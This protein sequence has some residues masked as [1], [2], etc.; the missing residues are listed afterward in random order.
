M[1]AI[2]HEAERPELIRVKHRAAVHSRSTT[3]GSC[4]CCGSP[5]AKVVDE[6]DDLDLLIDTT[7]QRR[8]L[9]ELPDR[10]RGGDLLSVARD[11]GEYDELA[12]DADLVVPVLLRVASHCL[13]LVFDVEHTMT[14]ASGAARSTKTQH[15]VVWFQRQW[16][17]RGGWGKRFLFLGPKVDQAFILS[18][19]W[20]RGEGDDNPPVCPLEL[21]EGGRKGLPSQTEREPQTTMVDGSVVKMTHTQ[22]DGDHIGGRRYEAILWTEMSRTRDAGNYVQ[23]RGRVV[24]SRGQ[25]YGDAVPKPA[26]W[27]GKSVVEVAE[28]QDVKARD[29]A[30]VGKTY[31][32][33]VRVKR[34]AAKDNPWNDEEETADFREDLAAIDERIAMREGDG[35]WIGDE[36]SMFSD[37][38]DASRHTFDV[39]GFDKVLDYLG[40]FDCT[41]QASLR[42]FYDPH[43]WIV[44]VDVNANPHT[45]LIGKIGVPKNGGDARNPHHWHAF[46]IGLLQVWRDPSGRAANDMR[47]GDSGEAAELLASWEGG[48]FKGAGVLI[49]ATSTYRKHNA[50]GAQNVNRGAIPREDYEKAG[51][52]VRGPDRWATA[53][54][55]GRHNFKNP[56]R[57]DSGTVARRM[58]KENRLHIGRVRCGRLLR[59]VRD[60]LTEPDGIT[61]VKIT[62]TNQDRF[63]GS[64]IDCLRYW[65]WP[66]FAVD[67][68][69]RGGDDRMRAHA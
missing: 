22:N 49:D 63:V 55:S 38:F 33:R 35:D 57:K 14:L 23:A 34:L 17:L 48:R 13:D 19:K 47:A 61:P 62:N 51:F 27:V 6:F 30:R 5:T 8:W 15:G 69:E 37:V 64:C 66:F 11:V 32:P 29:A 54:K 42:W 16:A 41:K 46:M 25:M 45:A 43:D 44:A 39:E 4:P 56:D 10:C 36:N 65:L 26:N 31:R 67:P 28:E 3:A 2:R 52:E 7:E 12:A 68:D 58:F 60:Q 9:R 40:F 21:V 53:N 24:S 59:A 20:L 50:G 1:R 18:D